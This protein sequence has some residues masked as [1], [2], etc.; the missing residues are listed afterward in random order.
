MKLTNLLGSVVLGMGMLTANAFGSTIIQTG[1]FTVTGN[2]AQFNAGSSTAVN[3]ATF[4][5][6]SVNSLITT[7]LCGIGNTCSGATLDQV[8]FVV[9]GNVS[10]TLTASNPNAFT[11]YIGP[12]SGQG[13]TFAGGATSGRAIESDA[14]LTLNDPLSNVATALPIASVA[15]DTRRRV[16]C[17][18]GTP[19][20]GNFSNCLAVTPGTR[21]FNGAGVADGTGSYVRADGDFSTFAVES[22]YVTTGAGVVSFTLGLTS[23]TTAGTLFNGITVP[24]NATRQN[25]VTDGVEV[26]YFYSFSETTPDAVPEPTTLLLAGS[27]FALAAILRK[28][29]AR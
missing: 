7:V 18:T 10:A 9:H 4:N 26:T 3:V 21:V 16:S 11:A 5:Q 23:A 20:S 6:T 2:I 19:S 22:T 8:D 1:S 12:L 27:A 29:T 17:G 28:R 15:T 14:T 24:G 13:G 25:A